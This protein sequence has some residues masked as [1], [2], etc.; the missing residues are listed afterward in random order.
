V[1][2]VIAREREAD[3]EAKREE[4]RDER[5]DERRRSDRPPPK[6]DTGPSVEIA[7]D[8]PGFGEEVTHSYMPLARRKSAT[9]S[10]TDSDRPRPSAEPAEPVAIPRAPAAPDAKSLG[11]R[12]GRSFEEWAPK[13]PDRKSSVWYRREVS[14][15]VPTVVVL[16]VLHAVLTAVLVQSLNVVWSTHAHTPALV[17]PTPAPEPATTP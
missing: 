17:S 13:I 6:V 12:D 9:D 1:I 14:L 16:L 7:R 15:T 11:M 4:K 3:R 2:A 10:H 5:R 8:L